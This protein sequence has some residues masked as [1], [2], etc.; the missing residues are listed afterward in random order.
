MELQRRFHRLFGP[1]DTHLLLFWPVTLALFII[2]GSQ[3]RPIPG[4][5]NLEPTLNRGPQGR[6]PFPRGEE[7]NPVKSK[8]KT[9]P[10]PG[11]GYPETNVQAEG[12]KTYS[13]NDEWW[14]MTETAFNP[15]MFYSRVPLANG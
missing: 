14:S 6:G 1:L 7:V 4:L 8:F 3:A 2:T 13:W 11:M 15:S 12:N 5:Q 9:I 10:D